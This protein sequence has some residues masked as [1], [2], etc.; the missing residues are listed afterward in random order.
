MN[1]GNFNLIE[2]ALKTQGG[3]INIEE[4]VKSEAIEFIEADTDYIN[5]NCNTLLPILLHSGYLTMIDE[6]HLKIPNYEVKEYFY[7]KM[8]T[9]LIERSFVNEMLTTELLNCFIKNIEDINSYK[10]NMQKLFLDN[11]KP[12]NQQED[13]FLALFAGIAEFAN[14][15]QLKEANREVYCE[16]STNDPK[17]I[18]IFFLPID[19]T[20]NTTMI[21]HKNK[22]I[23]ART[24]KNLEQHFENAFWQVHMNNYI[25]KALNSTFNCFEYFTRIII[26]VLLFQ[27]NLQLK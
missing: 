2:N 11:I 18:D 16:A 9:N 7:N 22:L 19:K 3:S 13:D 6:R 12:S 24:T 4:L 8:L 10:K 17:K 23:N 25:E 14:I 5:L 27:Q 1:T 26:R 21:I 20:K 15:L